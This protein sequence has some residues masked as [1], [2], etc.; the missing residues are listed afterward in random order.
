MRKTMTEEQVK[1]MEFLARGG[2]PARTIAATVGCGANTVRSHMKKRG[3]PV[4]QR[5]GRPEIIYSFYLTKTGKLLCTGTLRDCAEALGL[6]A[7]SMPGIIRKTRTGRM[8]KYRIQS[9]D[10]SKLEVPPG[11]ERSEKN[12]F[13]TAECHTSEGGTVCE[14]GD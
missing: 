4:S 10:P 12:G 2:L 9:W 6:S 14:E 7:S 5:L 1:T 13:E 8:R 3:V 11:R